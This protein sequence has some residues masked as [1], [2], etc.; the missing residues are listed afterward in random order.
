MSD[1]KTLSSLLQ[2]WRA[3]DDRR[4]ANRSRLFRAMYAYQQSF[5]IAANFVATG[6]SSS[7]RPNAKNLLD[8]LLTIIS[9]RT[10]ANKTNFF[11]AAA[12]DP[13]FRNFGGTPGV[14]FGPIVRNS[15]SALIIDFVEDI[16]I[17]FVGA[18][19]D[20]GGSK[21]I[22]KEAVEP[23]P[24]K[25]MLRLAIKVLA[26]TQR[27]WKRKD[28]WPTASLFTRD[29]EI[30]ARRAEHEWKGA[31]DGNPAPVQEIATDAFPNGQFRDPKSG[32]VYDF[33]A[34]FKQWELWKVL[35]TATEKLSR[36]QLLQAVWKDSI[37]TDDAIRSMLSELRK[38]WQRQG[39]EDF[40][41]AIQTKAGFISLNISH[42]QTTAA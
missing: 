20:A 2:E 36:N 8:P 19:A 39:R 26:G 11:S 40:A 22:D 16:Q 6:W 18:V 7:K 10:H 30:V 24:S 38:Y 25:R 21:A 34:S 35:W 42:K 4:L 23:L 5:H 41:D 31:F 9:H 14:S 15:Y 28:F 13:I 29:A 1:R 17:E 27:R 12:S 3:Y 37:V 33:G 32:H